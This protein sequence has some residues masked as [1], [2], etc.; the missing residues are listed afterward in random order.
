ME[1]FD[2]I[3]EIQKNNKYNCMCLYQ[4]VS[5]N[6][7]SNSYETKKFD[8]KV[9]DKMRDKLKKIIK[10]KVITWQQLESYYKNLIKIEKLFQNG[11]SEINYVVK[12]PSD[13]I[14]E[15]KGNNFD[16]LILTKTEN[17]SK[18]EFPSLSNYEM[19]LKKNFEKYNIENIDI[20]FV[21]QNNETTVYIDMSNI[22]E[23]DK[24]KFKNLFE[25]FME[26]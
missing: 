13:F 1:L 16:I 24:I 23:N 14:E 17:I 4:S 2:K 3:I 10:N 25:N 9:L 19:V 11:T 8:K 26:T 15:K 7:S 20:I 12:S 5:K 6:E 21:S 22:R 18:N